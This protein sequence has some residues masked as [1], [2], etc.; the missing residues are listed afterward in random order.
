M[1]AVATGLSLAEL[2]GALLGVLPSLVELVGGVV[3]EASPPQVTDLAIAALGPANVIVL[4]AGIVLVALAIGTAVGA[5][6]ARRFSLAASA[7]AAFAL[8]GAGSALRDASYGLAP[9]LIP[10]A[11]GAVTA[12]LVLRWLLHRSGSAVG[13]RAVEG[14]RA[15]LRGALGVATLALT[16]GV[17][18]RVLSARA[19]SA[20]EAVTARARIEVPLVPDRLPP[21]A[22]EAS[23][24]IDGL[25]PL[26]TPNGDFY[27]VDTAIRSPQVD[28]GGWALRIDGLVDRPLRFDHDELLDMSTDEAD[29]LLTCVSNEVGGDLAGTARWQGVRLDTLLDRAGVKPSGTQV[30]GRSVDGFTAGFPTTAALDGRDALVAVAMNGEVLPIAHGFPARLV[31][32]GLYGY[33]SATKWLSEIELAT[34]EVDGYW[35]PRGWAKEAPVKVASRIDVPSDGQ[36]VEEG[37]VAVAGVAWAPLAG[38]GAVQVRVDDGPWEDAT[39]AEEL[40]AVSWRQWH[41]E[42]RAAVGAH[43]LSVR[44]I[45]RDG[46]A[47]VGE[48]SPPRPAGATGYHRIAARVV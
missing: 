21:P 35:V 7:I 26:H 25:S 9:A 5:V 18:G 20:G 46:T 2:L 40:S 43:S 3:V 42:W 41:F 36:D 12:I 31:V 45:D 28:P 16:G 4:Q 23:L 38:V 10:A 14:R 6:G 29:I 33:V 1:L 17:A 8:L 19:G 13:V 34:D 11:V 32:A 48:E 22:G 30:I 15:F 44:A 37:L 39:L 27:I 47:Q 24:D